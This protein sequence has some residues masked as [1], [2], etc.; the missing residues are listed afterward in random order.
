M[1]SVNNLFA[2]LSESRIGLNYLRV[3]V[4][5]STVIND[6]LHLYLLSGFVIRGKKEQLFTSICRHDCPAIS[7]VGAIAHIVDDEDDD[8]TTSRPINVTGFL[9][10][11]LCELEEE[12]FSFTETVSERLNRILGEVFILDDELVEVVPEEISTDCASMPVVNTEE[13]AFGP[14]VI[15]V[16]FGLGFHNIQNDSHSVLVVVSYDALIRVSTITSNEAISLVGELGILVVGQ[17]AYLRAGDRLT[18]G[19]S[20]SSLLLLFLLLLTQGNLITDL[21]EIEVPATQTGGWR[22]FRRWLLIFVIDQVIG[23]R[24]L[25]AESLFRSSWTQTLFDDRILLFGS[26]FPWLF[27]SLLL[28]VGCRLLQAFGRRDPLVLVLQS[29]SWLLWLI[30]FVIYCSRGI[31]ILLRKLLLLVN[32]GH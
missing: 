29:H 32:A 2:S 14:L 3:L 9:L 26:R 21:L 13:G 11:A 12:P 8:R 7:S 31:R 24:F 27:S 28:I 4:D 30:V 10:L 20:S 16:V 19:S 25:I 18:I 6:S 15:L 1:R 22:L 23:R 5:S 17:N